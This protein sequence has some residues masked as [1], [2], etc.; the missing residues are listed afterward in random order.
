MTEDPPCWTKS[1]LFP[2][3]LCHERTVSFDSLSSTSGS[4]AVNETVLVLDGQTGQ[5]P[6]QL[7]EAGLGC[8]VGAQQQPTQ[9]VSSRGESRREEGGKI[10]R[11]S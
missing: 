2:S 5:L 8:Q 7:T 11:L 1:L 4:P 10:W 3:D 9:G 6:L